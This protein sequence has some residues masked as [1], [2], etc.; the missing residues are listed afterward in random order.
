VLTHN[1]DRTALKRLFENG[2]HA[3]PAPTT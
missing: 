1:K 2:R 3:N